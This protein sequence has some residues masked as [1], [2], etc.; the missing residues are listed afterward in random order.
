MKTN[1]SLSSGRQRAGFSGWPGIHAC[2]LLALAT[3]IVW[4]GIAGAQSAKKIS[5]NTYGGESDGSDASD[6][7]T[8]GDVTYFTADDGLYGGHGRELWKTDGTLE[9]TEMVAD[10]KEG[11]DPSNPQN[12]TE[13]NGVLYFSAD[14]GANGR[15]LWIY[16]G[17]ALT[18]VDINSSGDSNPA[19]MAAFNGTVY[20]SAE[21]D[22]GDGRELWKLDGAS[23]VLADDIHA[24][25]GSDPSE[26]V[27]MGSSL[28][29]AAD[30]GVDGRQVCR[31][32][33]D[34]TTT[35]IKNVSYMA[36]SSVDPA[37]LSAYP[38]ELV[39]SGSTLYYTAEWLN[40]EFTQSGMF[41]EFELKRRELFV[42]DGTEAGT[43]RISDIGVWESDLPSGSMVWEE[44]DANVRELT[45]MNG[46]LYFVAHVPSYAVNFTNMYGGWTE[47]WKTDG[48][49]AGTQRITQIGWIDG[50][51]PD[52]GSNA[53]IQY[54]TAMGSH[55]Y[56]SATDGTLHA[57]GKHGQELWRTDG[58]PAGTEL[59][60]D[61]NLYLT[62]SGTSGS[63]YINKDGAPQHLCVVNTSQGERLFFQANSGPSLQVDGHGRELWMTDG[64]EEGTVEVKDIHN[65]GGHSDPADIVALGNVAIF[66]ADTDY[67]TYGREVFV[68]DGTEAGTHMLADVAPG[69]SHSECAS[70]TPM[71][72]RLFFSANN[73]T[74]GS[75]LWVSD[76]TRAGTTLVK[77]IGPNPTNAPYDL[78]PQNGE[79]YFFQYSGIRRPDLWRT[80][81]TEAGT[82]RVKSFFPEGSPSDP[83]T[84]SEIGNP[85]GLTAFNDAVYFS[86]YDFELEG[87][88]F[89]TSDG[90]ESGTYMLKNIDDGYHHPVYGG[91]ASKP[92]NYI[93]IGDT[94][95]FTA[96]DGDTGMD[97]WMSDGTEA[98]TERVADI[99]IH[100][101]GSPGDW[102]A[103]GSL[104][105]WV[106]DT[107]T[108]GKELWFS[109][110]TA[111]GTVIAADINPGTADGKPEN[112]TVC[113]GFLFFSANDGVNGRELWISD[114]TPAGTTLLADIN[115]GGNSNPESLAAVGAKLYFSADDGT[116]GE[117]LWVY[118]TVADSVALFADINES[119]DSSPS[120]ITTIGGSVFLF[121]ADNGASGRELWI[122]DGTVTGTR[123][124]FDLA[125]GS[126]SS[127]PLQ[128]TCFSR[129]VAFLADDNT[130][131]GQ[132]LWVLNLRTITP[133]TDT[134]D[135]DDQLQGRI[136][137]LSL[138]I[139]NDGDT[140]ISFTEALIS[141]TAGL[142]AFTVISAPEPG[143]TIAP[144]S[145][146]TIEVA[147]RP[148]T[149]G[150][151]TSILEIHT[152]DLLHPVLEI[153]LNGTGLEDS[154]P[155]TFPNVTATPAEALQGDEVT[156]TFDASEELQFDPSVE[157]NGEPAVI[158]DETNGHY[159]FTTTIPEDAVYGPVLIKIQGLDLADN[160]GVYA[161]S[162][163]L[164]VVAQ[165]PAAKLPHLLLLCVLLSGFGLYSLQRRR[166]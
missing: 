143:A 115:P 93:V 148:T 110:G 112:L 164:E 8:V 104:L 157:V 48:T 133:G 56:F 139:Y 11:P 145:H 42:T 121:A 31:H 79:L 90:T 71:D 62:G 63:P 36:G 120:E 15:E 37:E 94:L 114:G 108:Y 43:V 162:N 18:R 14:D 124:L 75:E 91:W 61:I 81:G 166:T 129:Y 44:S 132:E 80:D 33:T 34:G 163:E 60:K 152:D 135:F 57:D 74:D 39:V 19:H 22:T 49:L 86:A 25:A 10:I 38:E 138:D 144:G 35:M 128:L 26:L 101:A 21:G 72:D 160:L 82:V 47:V 161:S 69:P 149:P 107:N 3:V 123:L 9:G 76:G 165:V 151:M 141:D 127:A 97:L 100:A 84:P 116:N 106:V 55:L 53:D 96:D 158:Q 140:A 13:V 12:L 20:F 1:R 52:A 122:S 99:D 87:L 27:V 58:T 50:M 67:L 29:F 134:L 103:L 45:L 119:G 23:A 147:F 118:D 155:P 17:S 73:G 154:T 68:S 89:W 7:L 146:I 102:V 70:L 156:I 30:N 131:D 85:Y 4:S 111:E 78:V 113:N 59:V 117:E 105:C 153:P 65:K 159:T 28:Y 126:A 16:N 6:F 109:D 83:Q 32:E 92:D 125:T 77:E 64:T 98:G 95:F 142:D 150:D 51:S 24:T 136:Q 2:T 41:G 40:R 137:T 130:I 88:E 5:I 46:T 66:S 54:L